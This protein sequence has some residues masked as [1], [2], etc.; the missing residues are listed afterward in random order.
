MCGC[1]YLNGSLAMSVAQI[2]TLLGGLLSVASM[3]DCSFVT[4]DPT[5][6]A[7]E[8]G[9]EIE[10]I[11]VGFIFF[12]K[13][14]RE[15]Y[16]YNDT[17]IMNQLPMYWNI[18]GNTWVAAAGLTFTCAALSW[19]FF[20]YSISF[21][22]SS[23]VKQIR[24]LNGFVLAGVMTICQACTFIVYGKDFCQTHNCSF[25]RGSG[26]SIGAMV[27]F[28]LAGGGFFCS[29]DYPGIQGLNTDRNGKQRPWEERYEDEILPDNKYAP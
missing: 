4:I 10:S 20:F 29:S 27:C 17:D 3:I 5:T 2:F 16:W 7:L 21:C 11:G 28:L 9:L 19:W 25:S 1:G 18:L 8:G 15:C 13:G 26:T 22:C 6:I 23:Q 12:Q 14:N 24:H